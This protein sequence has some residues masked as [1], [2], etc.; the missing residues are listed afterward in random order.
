MPL[1][2]DSTVWCSLAV[3]FASVLAVALAAVGQLQFDRRP[4]RRPDWHAGALAA[5]LAGLFAVGMGASNGVIGAAVAGAV[6]GAWLARRRNLTRRPCLVALLG[7]GMGLAVMSGGFARY[8]SSAAQANVE[9]IGLYVAVFIG[10]LI[11]ATSA[12][13]FCKLRGALEP[14]AVA[15]PGHDI[16]NLLALLLCGWLGYGF[17]TEQAQPFGFAALLAMSALACAMGVHL[18]MS[19]EYSDGHESGGHDSGTLAFAARCRS[20]SHSLT[21]GKRGL[22]AR[23]VWRGGEE[24]TWTLR[25]ITRGDVRTAAYSRCRSERHGVSVDGRQRM[26]AHLRA[27]RATT[28]R[29]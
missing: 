4:R 24:Q 3:L 21:T 5:A 28:R 1:A 19:R 12:I 27:T 10:A 11:F 29:A 6:P 26:C 22:L 8:L 16:V 13:A 25:D 7:S 14:A 15:R 18:M 20:H 9:R 2:Y 23:I 17:V